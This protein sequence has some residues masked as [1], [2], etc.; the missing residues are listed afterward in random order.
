MQ[1][2]MRSLLRLLVKSII[3]DRKR[4][5]DAA[6]AREA[7]HSAS[8]AADTSAQ[9]TQDTGTEAG[10]DTHAHSYAH[11]SRELTRNGK[12]APRNRFQHFYCHYGTHLLIFFFFCQKAVGNARKSMVESLTNVTA[13]NSDCYLLL[14]EMFYVRLSMMVLIVLSPKT[15]C[16]ALFIPQLQE[17]YAAEP[18]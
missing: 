6:A 13:V 16:L 9:N 4:Q 17:P 1:A 2:K 3:E 11:A 8:P 18:H 10:T 7:H 12:L 14:P 5:A 15:L